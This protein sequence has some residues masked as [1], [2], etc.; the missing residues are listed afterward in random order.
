[1]FKIQKQAF[2]QQNKTIVRITMREFHGFVFE[3]LKGMQMLFDIIPFGYYPF[4]V[5]A[6]SN[7]LCL[8]L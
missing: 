2:I 4:I 5:N 3:I 1:M 8:Y 6:I 7:C